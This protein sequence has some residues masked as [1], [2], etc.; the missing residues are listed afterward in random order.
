MYSPTNAFDEVT[1][2][3]EQGIFGFDCPKLRHIR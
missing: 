2:I 1:D 3:S